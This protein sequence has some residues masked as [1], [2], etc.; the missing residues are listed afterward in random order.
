M[1]ICPGSL[2][3][4]YSL[5]AKV[6]VIL[7]SRIFYKFVICNP[8]IGIN[9]K[10]HPFVIL[11]SAEIIGSVQIVNS[12]AERGAYAPCNSVGSIGVC[13]PVGYIRKVYC[14]QASVVVGVKFI[15]TGSA[16]DDIAFSAR[17]NLSRPLRV[18]RNFHFNIVYSPYGYRICIIAVAVGIIIIGVAACISQMD[19]ITYVGLHIIALPV[20]RSCILV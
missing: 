3:V 20:I 7:V 2:I 8:I 9:G 11:Y 6:I 19:Y 12:V 5:R 13:L 14:Y 15:D 1:F 16:V 4:I 18:C 10:F 17:A